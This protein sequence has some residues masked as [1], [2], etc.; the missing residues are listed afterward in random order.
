MATVSKKSAALSARLNKMLGNKPAD[1]PKAD[2]AAPAKPPVTRAAKF[3]LTDIIR[4]TDPKKPNPKRG[5]TAAWDLYEIYL[6][7]PKGLTVGKYLE[8]AASTERPKAG[9][10][11]IAWDVAR[12]YITVT[13]K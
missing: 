6:K 11:A 4:V 5:R 9:R 10:A 7:N 8:L 12:K 2:K 1:K 3:A 13:S